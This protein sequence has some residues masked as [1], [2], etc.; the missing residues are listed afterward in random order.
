[1]DRFEPVFAMCDKCNM[2]ISSIKGNY[3]NKIAY[4]NE[5]VMEKELT[6][7]AII[8]GFGEALD[9]GDLKMYLQAQTDSQGQMIGAEALVRWIDR[10]NGGM[11]F[12][13]SFIGV[14]EKARLIHLL[15]TFMWEKACM[16]LA[17]WKK[18]GLDDLYI[19]VN[20][21]VEDQYYI[22]I[23]KTM[24]KLVE[25]Y[26]INP[27]NLK[28]EITESIFATNMDKHMK[29][30]NDLR[31]YGFDIE[32]DD[33]GSG[34]SSLTVLKDIKADVL[35]LDME[36]LRNIKDIDRTRNILKST[37]Q[38][39]KDLD[40]RVVSEGV[41]TEEQFNMMRDLDC[42]MFQGY[43]FSKPISVEDFEEKYLT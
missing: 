14:L 29:M 30:V 17:D 26:D 4:Y 8:N 9:K 34:Y 5:Q 10:E 28:L 18:R 39:A 24:K 12:P 27:K 7:N 1:M 41:E 16:K 33:F 6:N 15:D 22:D 37:I 23:F 11:R 42:D 43:Y 19:S 36:F 2:A 31:G 35:K 40:M 38:I 13:A 3:T 20:I 32:I 25:K 21:S